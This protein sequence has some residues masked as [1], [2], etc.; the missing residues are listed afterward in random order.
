MTKNCHASI[1]AVPLIALIAAVSWAQNTAGA[2]PPKMKMTTELPKGIT[3]PDDIK[4]R[5]G[6]LVI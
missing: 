3:T 2:E 6:A 5:V 4:T 1:I